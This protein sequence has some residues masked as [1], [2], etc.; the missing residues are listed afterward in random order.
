MGKSG[1]E[2]ACSYAHAG[3]WRKAAHRTKA[4]FI[5]RTFVRVVRPRQ[6]DLLALAVV[7]A[8]LTS[9][10]GIRARVRIPDA[11]ILRRVDG[12]FVAAF[13]T[14]SVAEEVIVRAVEEDLRGWPAYCGP[15]RYAGSARR[16]IEV[17]IRHPWERFLQTERRALEARR[18]GRM[19]KALS[20]RL[21][22]ESQKDLDRIA[23][24]EGGGGARGAEQRAE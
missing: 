3:R 15:V 18:K 16:L 5:A 1:P 11:L 12:T 2:R 6:V 21:P 19:A 22:G 20:W 4:W 17:R 23:S 9:A 8:R 10:A 24:E 7:G 14:G 13:S